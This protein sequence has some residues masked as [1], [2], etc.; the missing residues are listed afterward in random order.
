[1]GA[2]KGDLKE[3][4]SGPGPRARALIGAVSR[5]TDHLVAALDAI[6]LNQKL[7]ESP[8]CQLRSLDRGLPNYTLGNLLLS[9]EAFATVTAPATLAAGDMAR[10]RAEAQRALRPIQTLADA[11]RGRRRMTLSGSTTQTQGSF[12]RSAMSEPQVQA[13]LAE[14]LNSLTA[15]VAF[16]EDGIQKR[17]RTLAVA[18]G[19]VIPTAVLGGAVA[20]I[21]FL[22]ASIAVATGGTSVT[23]SGLNIPLLSIRSAAT[24]T[25]TAK[26]TATSAT[27]GNQP[28]PTPNPGQAPTPKPGAKP[29]ATPAPTATPVPGSGALSVS[30]NSVDACQA[31]SSAFTIANTGGQSVNW[32]AS[33]YDATSISLTPSHG[34]L[35]P[36]Q[37]VTVTVYASSD[38]NGFITITPGGQTV[39]YTSTNC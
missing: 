12:L 17:K 26:P 20:L 4:A 8:T 30:P 1:M 24:A 28:T 32:S 25:T 7:R 21:I 38:A 9:C 22:I 2:G 3:P 37:S 27:T 11:V 39:N 15:L 16:E 5:A 35:S 31:S 13:A 33:G 29:T 10:L 23:P 14:L 36:G 19:C 18:P 34:T 6:G